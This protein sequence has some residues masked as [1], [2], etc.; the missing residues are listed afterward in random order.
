MN[1]SHYSMTPRAFKCVED[2]SNKNFPFSKTKRLLQGK[3]NKR[4]ELYS[5]EENL[6]MVEKRKKQLRTKLNESFNKNNDSKSKSVCEIKIKTYHDN[7]GKK[8]KRNN[9][10]TLNH[11]RKRGLSPTLSHCSDVLLNVI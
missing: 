3:K 1:L 11:F 9:S 5:R 2:C 8:H 7:F 6:K 4:S 10:C